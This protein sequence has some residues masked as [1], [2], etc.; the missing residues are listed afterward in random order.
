[1]THISR[2][3]RLVGTLAF[4]LMSFG[5]CGQ[6]PMVLRSNCQGVG[7]APQEPAG[8]G[9]TV[10]VSQYSCLNEGGPLEGSVMTGTTIWDSNKGASV[11]LSGSGVIRKPGS[12]VVYVV[13]ESTNSTTMVDGKVTGFS[14]TGKGV[15][16][17]ATGG[18]SSLAGKSFTFKFHSTGFGRFVVDTSLD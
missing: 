15:Y 9:R 18:A 1:M 10:S 14:G 2:N 13:T 7:A 17:L 5:A 3:L 16:Q 6:T 12:L 8:E 11:S 4:T